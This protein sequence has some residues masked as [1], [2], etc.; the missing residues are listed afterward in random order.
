M[1]GF[2]AIQAD[3]HVVI[4]NRL[5]GMDVLIGDEGAVAGEPHI[6]PHVLGTAGNV[7]NIRAQQGFA[8]RENQNGHMKLL[9]VIHDGKDFFRR[10]L[11]RKILVGRN[12]IAVFA[13]Q[14]A[15]ADQVPDNDRAGRI[16][17]RADFGRF[18]DLVHVLGDSEH[19]RSLNS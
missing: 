11:T 7:E 8:A 2:S 15:S 17:L 3:A 6:K 14:V 4:A 12:R 19:S 13:G 1:G 10:Q 18:C 9:Q 16:A 5:N